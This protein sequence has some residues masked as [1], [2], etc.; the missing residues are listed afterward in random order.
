MMVVNNNL[1]H[2]VGNRYKGMNRRRI[3]NNQYKWRKD[4]NI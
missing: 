4:N 3:I 1:N 2:N